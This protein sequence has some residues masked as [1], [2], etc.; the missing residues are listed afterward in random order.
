MS[1]KEE[2]RQIVVR[3]EIEKP[4]APLKKMRA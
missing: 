4:K 3:L 2:E 1:L